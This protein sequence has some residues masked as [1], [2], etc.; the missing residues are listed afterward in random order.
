MFVLVFLHSLILTSFLNE[1]YVM[2]WVCAS[3]SM[4]HTQK[5]HVEHLDC[6]IYENT[7]LTLGITK[8]KIN[9][10]LTI[11]ISLIFE[12]TQQ[13]QLIFVFVRGPGG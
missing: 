3:F 9:H 13:S 11:Y 1:P 7:I 10:D 6:L 4:R 8:H 5:M 2:M 12:K